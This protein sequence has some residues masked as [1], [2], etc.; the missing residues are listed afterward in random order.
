MIFSVVLMLICISITVMVL[1]KNEKISIW[2]VTSD[3]KGFE[4]AFRTEEK[5]D[6]F[7][8]NKTKF[9]LDNKEKEIKYNKELVDL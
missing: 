6:N 7:I 8:K 3:V 9:S 4:G 1:N 2:I 5:A